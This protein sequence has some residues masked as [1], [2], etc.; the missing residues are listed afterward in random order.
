MIEIGKI[1]LEDNGAGRIYVPREVILALSLK[2]RDI[3]RLKTEDGELK[4]KP[5]RDL[6]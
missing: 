1:Y 5:L 6:E 2:H 3:L 4:A